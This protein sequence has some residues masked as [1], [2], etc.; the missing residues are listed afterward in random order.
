LECFFDTK[1]WD[2]KKKKKKKKL[3]K[4]VG[5][6]TNVPPETELASPRLLPIKGGHEQQTSSLGNFPALQ[7]L[8]GDS[9]SEEEDQDIT[10]AK[11]ATKTKDVPSAKGANL[12]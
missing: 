5:D 12:L 6:S 7:S 10:T 8:L 3:K 4:T 1:L 9:D 11:G 2:S